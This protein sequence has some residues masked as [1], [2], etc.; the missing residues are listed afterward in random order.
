VTVKRQARAAFQRIRTLLNAYGADFQ[1]VVMI[2]SFHDW[3][4]P[5]F[6]GDRMAQ[7]DALSSVKDEFMTEP[8]PAWTA[9]GTSGMIRSKG[10]VE[11]QMIAY[12]TQH[13]GSERGERKQDDRAAY[14]DRTDGAP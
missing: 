6:G 9:V 11:I 4:A 5:E 3:S 8:Y 14:L 7:L 13:R 1:N 2:N 10:I 12:V